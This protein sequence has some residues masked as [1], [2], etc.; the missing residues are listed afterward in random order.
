MKSKNKPKKKAKV[1]FAFRLDP[2]LKN[3]IESHGV[4]LPEFLETKI[5]EFLWSK[6]GLRVDV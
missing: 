2:D 5:K 4:Y 6:E 1:T 3:R